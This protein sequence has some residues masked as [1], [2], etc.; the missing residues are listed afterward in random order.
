[1][2]VTEDPFFQNPDFYPEGETSDSGSIADFAV[3]KQ[4]GAT[5]IG[6]LYCS[7]SASCA[8]SASE[9]KSAAPKVGIPFVYSAEMAMSAPNYTAQCLAAKQDHVT[10]IE[11]G[12]SSSIL[13]RVAT[14]APCRAIP[15]LD[16]GR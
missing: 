8:Q 5:N 3:A 12:D 2:D 15:D 11:I 16:R 4:A 6:T 13:A 7:E 10:S 1:M 14:T 9:I